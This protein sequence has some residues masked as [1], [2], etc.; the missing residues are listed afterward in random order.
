MLPSETNHTPPSGPPT[1]DLEHLFR[2]KF[3]EAEVPPRASLW[4]QIDHNLVVGQNETY[5]RRLLLYRWVAAASVALLVSFG[6]WFG[7]RYGGLSGGKPEL[8]ARTAASA[9]PGRASAVG[10]DAAS[11][12]AERL[13]LGQSAAEAAT[14]AASSTMSSSG[15]AA[16]N[17]A[18]AAGSASPQAAG[19]VLADAAV[20]ASQRA[21]GFAARL[22]ALAGAE[23]PRAGRTG[24]GSGSADFRS[25]VA[26]SAGAAGGP[27]QL[28]LASGP[29]LAAASQSSQSAGYSAALAEL[30]A[31]LAAL[32]SGLSYGRPALLPQQPLVASLTSAPG[33]PADAEQKETAGRPRRWRL[34]GSYAASAY[35]PNADFSRP[36]ASATYSSRNAPV[37]SPDSYGVAAA[38]YRQ[39]LRAGLGQR[40]A[41]TAS[42]TM[43]K[44]WTLLTGLEAAEQRASSRTSYGFLDS[45]HAAVEAGA[46]NMDPDIIQ[47]RAP[48]SHATYYRYRTAGLPVG[49]RYGTAKPGVSVYAKV[50]AVVNVLLNSRAELEGAPEATKVYNLASASS[51]YRRV[52]LAAR[53]GAGARYQPANARWSVSVGPTA[54]AGLNTLN[55]DPNQSVLRRSRPYSV[56]LEASVE[57]G[58]KSNS[59]LTP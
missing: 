48:V 33:Q 25:G 40:A 15:M 36:G 32:Q 24:T 4:E 45:H 50:G 57:F 2:Q 35:S 38:E 3:A 11:S 34:L 37:G 39:H 30:D 23:A 12:A 14:A 13:A 49:V 43:N 9:Q 52:Q 6:S 1:G 26:R 20:A 41:L 58:G 10:T 29:M 27:A 8:A 31:R 59:L 5:R 28:A 46:A 51:P 54:E 44:H 17:G 22:G 55:A 47:Y 19:A 53:A 7:L 56:G 42:Y 16:N 21:A 18:L